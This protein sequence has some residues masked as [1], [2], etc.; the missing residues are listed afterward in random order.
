MGNGGSKKSKP[1]KID[2]RVDF[3]PMV[4]MNMLLL[5][6]FMFSSTLSK[7]QVM[8]LVLPTKDVEGLTD[9]EQAKVADSQAITILLGE[10]NK[11]YYY[12][13]KVTEEMYEDPLSI[14]EVDY[15]A[16]GLR[17]VLSDRNRKA[18]NEVNELNRQ[19]YQGKI[20]DL[21]FNELRAEIRNAPGGQ[22]VVIK[23]TVLSTYRNLV[24]AL[25][26]MQIC[27]IGRYALVDPSEG[28]LVL[29][30]NFINYKEGGTPARE[31]DDEQ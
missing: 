5:T 29:M 22:V 19:R 8:D 28:D 15:S 31:E 3:T 9:E 16:S 12:F 20:N 1:R 11:V 26:E 21:E 10:D 25:D 4:D 18:I 7:P 27:N 30:E 6:F 17:K 23:P 2:L 24:D 13:G 14:D